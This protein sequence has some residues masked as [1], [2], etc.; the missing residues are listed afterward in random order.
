MSRHGKEPESQIVLKRPQHEERLA[1]CSSTPSMPASITPRSQG[2]DL[3]PAIRGVHE[4]MSTWMSSLINAQDGCLQKV[5]QRA[6]MSRAHQEHLAQQ[7][8]QRSMMPSMTDQIAYLSA[9][10]AHRDAQLEQVR[11]EKGQSF[12]PRSYRSTRGHGS[13]L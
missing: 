1:Q 7:V 5:A 10:L 6:S 8:A 11:A 9:Q 3:V 2:I 12:R 13:T 4:H